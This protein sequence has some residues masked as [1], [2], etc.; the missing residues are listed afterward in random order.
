MQTDPTAR[1]MRDNEIFIKCKCNGEGMS[2]EHD[3]FDNS[4]YFAYWKSGFRPVYMSWRE[5][6]RYCWHVIRT[7]K[8]YTDELILSQQDVDELHDF[9]SEQKNRS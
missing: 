1:T 6:L 3:T 5:R 2:V 8:A 4:Y 7:G 9:L